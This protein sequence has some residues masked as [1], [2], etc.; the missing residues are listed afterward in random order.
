[1]KDETTKLLDLKFSDG[2]HVIIPQHIQVPDSV[3]NVLTFGSLD[4]RFEIKENSVNNESNEISDTA[5][6]SVQ[7]ET[8]S[9]F[10]T[11][12]VASVFFC[13]F[14]TVYE[15]SLY[16]LICYELDDN[17]YLDYLKA[18]LASH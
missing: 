18:V 6:D 2:Q 3:K 5:A 9:K 4:A 7:A 16:V 8:V 12:S 14:T 11:R 17:I 13:L 1:M 15:C 10:S